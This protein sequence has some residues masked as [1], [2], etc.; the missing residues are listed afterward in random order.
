MKVE[1]CWVDTVDVCGPGLQAVLCTWPLQLPLQAV[2]PQ[3]DHG[4]H[5]C[6][7]WCA[8]T[9]PDSRVSSV[10]IVLDITL[11]IGALQLLSVWPFSFIL[12]KVLADCFIRDPTTDETE[13]G[14]M[15]E[16]VLLSAEV[17]ADRR[18]VCVRMPAVCIRSIS[19]KIQTAFDF[20]WNGT[21]SWNNFGKYYIVYLAQ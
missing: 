21:G 12:E 15:T 1:Y 19:W 5:I 14:W 10:V 11:N 20:C 17:S 7:P 6:A 4:T 8:P 9:R 3:V 2:S 16:H 13:E 18:T